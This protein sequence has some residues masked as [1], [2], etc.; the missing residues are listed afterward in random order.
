M[1][2][3]AETS[4]DPAGPCGHGS[5]ARSGARVE[6]YRGTAIERR[7]HASHGKRAIYRARQVQPQVR[8]TQSGV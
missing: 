2:G 6:S 4:D 1:G 8:Y 3:R 5:S 7:W